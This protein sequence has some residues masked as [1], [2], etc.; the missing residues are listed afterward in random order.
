MGRQVVTRKDLP[1]NKVDE[2]IALARRSADK[3]LTYGSVGIGSLHH[4]ILENVQS[5]A[6][7]KLAHVPYKGPTRR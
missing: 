3:P 4:L 7:T 5:L 6:G 2:L 1:V